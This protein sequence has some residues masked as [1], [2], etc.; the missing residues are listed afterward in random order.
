MVLRIRDEW[1]SKVV[2]ELLCLV[3]RRMFQKTRPVDINE[4]LFFQFK[5]RSS[6]LELFD[7]IDTCSELRDA[8]SRSKK[9][10]TF[11]RHSVTEET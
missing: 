6:F 5:E 3:Q 4:I 7:E 2:N 11:W 10:L 1:Q 8:P 9:S